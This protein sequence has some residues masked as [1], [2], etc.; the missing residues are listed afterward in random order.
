[1]TA[2]LLSC[3]LAPLVLGA[4]AAPRHEYPSLAIRDVERVSGQMEAA[5]PTYVPP[6]LT[7]AA[8][9]ELEALAE[10]ANAAHQ[11]FL[12]EVAAARQQ[13]AAARGAERGS[14]GWARAQVVIAALES[15][16]S[17]AMI[18]LADLDRIYVAAALEGT[19]L[20]RI[21]AVQQQVSAQVA[22]QDAAIGALIGDA[23]S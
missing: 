4:C 21:A 2:R 1:M 3:L 14:D 11:T 23:G 15:A 19:E 9:D 5:P 7:A 10:Q 8:G 22:Q 12:A 6:P 18:A 17:R 20:T 16:R 13:V